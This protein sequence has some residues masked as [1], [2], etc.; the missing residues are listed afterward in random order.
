MQAEAVDARE[1][2]ITS[3][4]SEFLLVDFN[5]T[6]KRCNKIARMSKGGSIPIVTG[7]I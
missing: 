7:F 6:K 3:E 2:I 4:E 1:L 5:E